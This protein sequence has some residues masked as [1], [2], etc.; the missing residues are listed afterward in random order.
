MDEGP[1]ERAFWLISIITPEQRTA[2]AFADPRRLQD[3]ALK[4]QQVLQQSMRSG[5][6]LISSPTL[7]DMEL[8]ERREE[9]T[10]SAAYARAADSSNYTRESERDEDTRGR[11][12]DRERE[13]DREY[14][15]D[16]DRDRDRTYEEE[17]EDED[18][19]VFEPRRR[20]HAHEED[21]LF[22][23][24][25]AEQAELRRLRVRCKLLES[26]LS[27]AR[28]PEEEQVLREMVSTQTR[29]EFAESQASRENRVHYNAT[30]ALPLLGQA[31]S[32]ACR[33]FGRGGKFASNFQRE[34]QGLS[35]SQT[36]RESA[37]EVY[38]R[39]DMQ[40]L[41]TPEVTV[42][43]SL[44]GAFASAASTDPHDTPKFRAYQERKRAERQKMQL[45]LTPLAYAAGAI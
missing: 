32:A 11:T 23:D 37:K 10:K 3:D 15:Y 29:K 42:G 16:R 22:D 4:A 27:S 33:S 12:R 2:L 36:M 28:A 1:N 35:Q 7:P 18:D 5:G 20:V 31:F 8:M 30:L 43:L 25:S 41:A 24:E 34:L 13:R 9:E 21:D 14:E 45:A 26:Q 19:L 40:L 44:L 17:D 39:Q 38:E 6:S